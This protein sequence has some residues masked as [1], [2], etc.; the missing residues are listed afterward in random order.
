MFLYGSGDGEASRLTSFALAY[1][2][3][4]GVSFHKV[5]N[6]FGMVLFH[7]CAVPSCWAY[8]IKHQEQR[9]NPMESTAFLD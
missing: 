6:A 7:Q 2:Y 8:V 3:L 4:V 5:N 9:I 1:D